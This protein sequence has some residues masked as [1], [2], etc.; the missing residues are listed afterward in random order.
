MTVTLD[1]LTGEKNEWKNWKIEKGNALWIVLNQKKWPFS[2]KSDILW[3]KVRFQAKSSKYW[4]FLSTGR[5][6]EAGNALVIAW[7]VFSKMIYF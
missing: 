6:T 5:Y 1:N 3:V 4:T 2:E 7:H